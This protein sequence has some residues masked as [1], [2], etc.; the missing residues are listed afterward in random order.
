MKKII[1][2]LLTFTMLIS[3]MGLITV[4]AQAEYIEVGTAESLKE[5]LESNGDKCDK[6]I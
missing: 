5:I 1:S 4:S 2:I 3:C 6:A